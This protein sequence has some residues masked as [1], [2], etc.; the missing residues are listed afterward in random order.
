MADRD[1]EFEDALRRALRIAEATRSLEAPIPFTD[2]AYEELS[3][4]T[5]SY[6]GDLVDV[7]FR[8]TRAGDAREVSAADVRRASERLS[9]RPH[10]R[11]S[12]VVGALGGLLLGAAIRNV[13]QILGA[14]TVTT[15][16]AA[17]TFV[18]GVVGT[19]MMTL[20]FVRD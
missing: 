10:N 14:S 3:Y 5:S 1:P 4:R 12:Q 15:E 7:S 9:A 19:A 6:I 2:A 8:I 16:S 11:R 18:C 13:L 20:G 17:L